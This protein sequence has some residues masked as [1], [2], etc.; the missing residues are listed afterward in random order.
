M[1]FTVR[2]SRLLLGGFAA[3]VVFAPSAQADIAV[4][5]TESAP[6][7]R[8]VITNRT[9]CDIATG[10]VAIDLSSS[11][12]G[13]IFDTD[14]S[15]PGENVA[16]PFEIARAQDVEVSIAAI[17][18]GATAAEIQVR[19]FK[20][21]GELAVTVDVDDSIRSGPRGVQMIAGSEIAGARVAFVSSAG[22]AYAAT[23][24]SKGAALIAL[25]GC[26]AS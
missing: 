6:K 8:F 10:A 4:Q 13:L 1:R 22:T 26:P 23:F 5:F 7:D 14:P 16:Q 24:D 11:A 2:L 25:T 15:G 17:P 20:P 19:D 21:G 3:L 12:S 9:A 18:D